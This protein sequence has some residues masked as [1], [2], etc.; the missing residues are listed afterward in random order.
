MDNQGGH[1]LADACS[2][3]PL[4]SF[5]VTSEGSLRRPDKYVFPASSSTT[6]PSSNAPH[7][8][9]AVCIATVSMAFP[10]PLAPGHTR[11][12][13]RAAVKCMGTWYAP[14]HLQIARPA[15]LSGA[16]GVAEGVCVE[17]D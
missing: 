17:A 5:S 14:A 9:M 4:G 6:P 12:E 11:C 7:L 15:L 13:V 1:T 2:V 8:S 3:V 16:A 10:S